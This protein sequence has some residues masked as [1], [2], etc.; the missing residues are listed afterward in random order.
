MV[1]RKVISA[2]R[3]LAALTLFASVVSNTEALLGQ[4]RGGREHSE[5][6]ATAEQ[7]GSNPTFG[8]IT[9]ANS[10]RYGQTRQQSV[11]THSHVDANDHCAH[12]HGVGMMLAVNFGMGLAQF[13]QNVATPLRDYWYLP[14]RS[15]TEPPRG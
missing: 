9:R 10:S 3:F 6:S 2:R 1:I 15:M 13:A 11:P 12:Q 5:N 4:V 7:H 8:E 14:D